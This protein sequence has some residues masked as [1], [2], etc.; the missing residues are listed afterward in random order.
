MFSV[1]YFAPAPVTDTFPTWEYIGAPCAQ[2]ALSIPFSLHNVSASLALFRPEAKTEY[3]TCQADLYF[4][5][6][7]DLSGG[8]LPDNSRARA[9][10]YGST[11]H[12]SERKYKIGTALPAIC[13]AGC[14]RT[15]R[16][17]FPG[18]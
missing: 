5:F 15:I 2:R 18:G 17:Q 12:R 13:R 3:K 8:L 16:G 10:M 7:R 6:A 1:W 11:L 14:C 9:S 4:G